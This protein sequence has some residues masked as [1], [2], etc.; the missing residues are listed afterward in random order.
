MKTPTCEGY[1]WVRFI[2]PP[3]DLTI[4]LYE[5]PPQASKSKDR[6]C[7][8]VVGSNEIFRVH[9]FEWLEPVKPMDAP[10]ASAD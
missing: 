2:N 10:A 4:A 9:E 7:V 1:W 6:L 5:P 8:E 3:C